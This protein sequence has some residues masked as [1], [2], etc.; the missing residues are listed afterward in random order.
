MVR[1]PA[2]DNRG[3]IVALLFMCAVGLVVFGLVIL[4]EAVFGQ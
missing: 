3:I 2:S 4:G 1:R